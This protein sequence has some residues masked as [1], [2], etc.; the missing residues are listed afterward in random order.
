M[1]DNFFDDD[2]EEELRIAIL[3]DQKDEAIRKRKQDISK[4]VK[5]RLAPAELDKF[6]LLRQKEDFLNRDSHFPGY[7]HDLIT[8]LENSSI[9]VVKSILEDNVD[10]LV[11]LQD[12]LPSGWDTKTDKYGRTFFRDN[13]KKI[14]S[15]YPETTTLINLY[16][17]EELWAPV[18]DLW[19]LMQQLRIMRRL[20][21][22]R[23]LEV[24][25]KP[26]PDGS[27]IPPKSHALLTAWTLH[28]AYIRALH[29]RTLA[30]GTDSTG[31][32]HLTS[33]L[34]LSFGLYLLE[35]DDMP[36]EP[37]SIQ[38]N[39]SRYKQITR[40]YGQ[41]YEAFVNFGK[42]LETERRLDGRVNY[43]KTDT[44]IFNTH[45]LRLKIGIEEF[46]FKGLDPMS[47]LWGAILKKSADFNKASD[48]AHVEDVL[49]EKRVV[50]D[51]EWYAMH[52]ALM[53]P[54]YNPR[55][56]LY[57]DTG[58]EGRDQYVLE[59]LQKMSEVN[60]L[61]RNKLLLTDWNSTK[62]W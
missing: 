20:A 10:K 36:R 22:G 58:E 39:L 4:Y 24:T 21:D 30:I 60:R 6:L 50:V 11:G 42:W 28:R 31:R 62:P 16:D 37:L 14:T 2:E 47:K 17:S 7:K 29:Y 46:L 48:V 8:P 41:L 56:F 43:T 12:Q 40:I 52:E 54:G 38:N 19:A 23:N 3:E 1:G 34:L 49:V 15:W 55:D 44:L 25:A 32:S 61:R 57:K 13:K 18:K 51:D 59:V 5:S 33:A 26:L 27:N 35:L 53:D 45:P 9:N